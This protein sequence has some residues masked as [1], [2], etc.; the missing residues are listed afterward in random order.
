[1]TPDAVRLLAV[2]L[3]VTLVVSVGGAGGYYT[4]GLLFDTQQAAGNF[5]VVTPENTDTNT[6][7]SEDTNET[8]SLGALPSGM[9]VSPAV[10]SVGAG[11]AVD[12]PLSPWVLV[13]QAGADRVVTQLFTGAPAAVSGWPARVASVGQAPVGH[14]RGG[15]VGR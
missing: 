4:A 11:L 7:T 15:V 12:V 5:S 6:N 1:V 13:D 9:A 2:A 3:V 14:Q 8:A 10:G